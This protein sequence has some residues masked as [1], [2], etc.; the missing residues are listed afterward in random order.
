MQ[1]AVLNANLVW[2]VK[3]F[4]PPTKVFECDWGESVYATSHLWQGNWMAFI[5][6]RDASAVGVVNATQ[7]S[8]HLQPAVTDVI[9]TGWMSPCAL[10]LED[11]K[12]FYTIGVFTEALLVPLHMHVS[13]NRQHINIGLN[14]RILREVIASFIGVPW[15]HHK[16]Q[17]VAGQ[18]FLSLPDLRDWRSL[19]LLGLILLLLLLRSL[20]F[21]WLIFLVVLLCVYIE[22]GISIHHITY[23]LLE[24]CHEKRV[25]L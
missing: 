23:S 10:G 14:C 9:K 7:N 16:E 6:L 2:S 8:C 3:C 17:N 20:L 12:K 24:N 22:S 4:L 1:F 5:F 11:T 25:A 15:K 21:I 18:I 13:L 19:I